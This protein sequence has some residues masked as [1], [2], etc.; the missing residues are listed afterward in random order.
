MSVPIC[1][2]VVLNCSTYGAR[3]APR[4]LLSFAALLAAVLV[5]LLPSC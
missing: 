4:A 3:V 2:A 5:T 1:F